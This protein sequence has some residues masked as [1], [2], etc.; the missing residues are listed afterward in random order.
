MFAAISG[1]AKAIPCT[2]KLFE[3]KRDPNENVRRMIELQ[4]CPC[5]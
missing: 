1:D 4:N 5:L 3:T 2:T